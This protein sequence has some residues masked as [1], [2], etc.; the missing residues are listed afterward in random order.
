MFGL[1]VVHAPHTIQEIREAD[2]ANDITVAAQF[3]YLDALFPGSMF[4][5]TTRDMDSWIASC[6]RWYDLL[7][8]RTYQQINENLAMLAIYGSTNFSRERW[9]AGKRTFENSVTEY[10]RQRSADL[11]TVN[12]IAGRAWSQLLPLLENIVPFPWE[13]RNP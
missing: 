9:I 2:F 12:I 13:N 8:Q 5:L 10:F 1:R 11:V 7:R 3:Q 4:L 6:E